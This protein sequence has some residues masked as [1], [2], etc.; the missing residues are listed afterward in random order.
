MARVVELLKE[1]ADYGNAY[2]F[3]ATGVR[4]MFFIS[5]HIVRITFTCTDIREGRDDSVEEQRV[6]GHMDCD[7]AQLDAILALI[8]DGLA[9][10]VDQP[11]DMAMRSSVVAH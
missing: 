8:R 4:R 2:E 11:R 9:A 3:T 6:S 10:L 1:A 5:P 7:V